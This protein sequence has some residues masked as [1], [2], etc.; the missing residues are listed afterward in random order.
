MVACEDAVLA[1]E[2]SE[3]GEDH[4]KTSKQGQWT[5]KALKDNFTTFPQYVWIIH[6]DYLHFLQR[7]SPQSS[8]PKVPSCPEPQSTNKSS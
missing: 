5:L 6:E 1:V 7:P 3:E 8:K 2:G 4:A